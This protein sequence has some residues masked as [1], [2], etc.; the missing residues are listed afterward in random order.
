MRGIESSCGGAHGGWSYRRGD[1][2]GVGHNNLLGRGSRSVVADDG[3]IVVVCGDAWW[4]CGHGRTCHHRKWRRGHPRMWHRDHPR[5][6]HGGCTR[7]SCPR[8]GCRC[9]CW[10]RCTCG[11]GERWHPWMWSRRRNRYGSWRRCKRRQW[12]KPRRWEER[13]RCDCVTEYGGQ[14]SEG[15]PG[16]RRQSVRAETLAT[17]VRGCW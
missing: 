1:G 4:R 16:N 17:V 7:M 6:W 8:C 3:G 13:W 11:C 2:S 5:K 10:R 15:P 14:L 9:G 12:G